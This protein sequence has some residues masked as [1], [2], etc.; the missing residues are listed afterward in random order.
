MSNFGPFHGQF[1]GHAR[2]YMSLALAEVAALIVAPWL[3]AWISLRYHPAASYTNVLPASPGWLALIDGVGIILG[4]SWYSLYR[5]LS[6]KIAAGAP[7]FAFLDRIRLSLVLIA[8]TVIAL[9][10]LVAI[11]VR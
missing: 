2:V 8:Q 5:R 11:K 6:A 7:G 1:E 3:T 10:I 4:W 9:V